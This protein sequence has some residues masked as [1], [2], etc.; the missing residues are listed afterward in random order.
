[1]AKS[2]LQVI[3]EIKKIEF[4]YDE[5]FYIFER[6]SERKE[7]YDFIWNSSG[8]KIYGP[9]QGDSTE[10]GER[11]YKSLKRKIDKI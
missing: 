9:F 10:E 2:K 3:R 8:E 4:K 5:S 1:M 6:R 11:I 7:S